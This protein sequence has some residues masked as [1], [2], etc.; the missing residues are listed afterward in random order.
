MCP[1]WTRL[2]SP[3]GAGDAMSAG[4]MMARFQ[5]KDWREAL[6]LGTA[7]AAA[8]VGNPGTCECYLHQVEA[9]MPL[10]QSVEV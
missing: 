6:A 10:V 5:G 7:M 3:A 9:F 1:P 8:V 2:V 4:L